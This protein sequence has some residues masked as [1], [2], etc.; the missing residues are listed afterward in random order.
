MK[1][2][3]VSSFFLILVLLLTGCS[4]QMAPEPRKED[5]H[6]TLYY[7]YIST[8][9]NCQ[10][11]EKVALPLI[12]EQFGD[13]VKI[14]SYD[15]DA[16]STIFPYEQMLE[17]LEKEVSDDDYGQ[18]PTVAFDGSFMKVGIASGQEQELV[19]DMLRAI[20]GEA[21]SGELEASRYLYKK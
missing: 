7:F 1:K 18:A 4:R 13:E 20:N 15:L 19:N 5:G 8:C 14:V 3:I 16:L 10:E 2:K 11:F 6:Y 9:H 21:L 17:Q 12:E